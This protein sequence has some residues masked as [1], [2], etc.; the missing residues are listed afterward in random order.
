[1]PVLLA[2]FFSF[3]LGMTVGSFLNVCICR[4]PARMSIVSPPSHCPGCGSRLTFVD[5]FPLFSY[6]FLQGKCRHCGAPISWQYPAVEL[7]AGLLFW[8][9]FWRFG[10]SP[11]FLTAAILFSILIVVSVIDMQHYIIPNQLVLAGFILGGPLNL[12]LLGEAR[13]AIAGFLLGGGLLL[14]V[15]LLSGLILSRSGMGGGDIKLAAMAGIYLGWQNTLLM[16]FAA[17]LA[18]AVAGIL[19]LQLRQRSLSQEGM[20]KGVTARE[21]TAREATAKEAIAKE[22]ASGGIIPKGAIPFGPFISLGAVLSMLW[23]HEIISWYWN[24]F[25]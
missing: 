11:R 19:I 23:G 6:V 24:I 7:A 1:M 22:V 12:V 18:G 13:S 14:A 3:L 25:S 4:I 10:L 8:A 2:Q 15:A 16:L 20:P 17:F 5:L 9:A 21:A